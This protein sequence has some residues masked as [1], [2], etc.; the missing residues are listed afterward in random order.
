MIAEKRYYTEIDRLPLKMM[1]NYVLI[2]LNHYNKEERTPGGVIMSSG[3]DDTS[4]DEYDKYD[5]ID[6]TGIV[7]LM[8]D[9]LSFNLKDLTGM[10]WHTQLDIQLGDIVWLDHIDANT[11]ERY[12]YKGDYYKILRY[13]AIIVAKRGIDVICCN[14]YILCS[15]VEVDKSTEY[16]YCPKKDNI[17]NQGVV[18]YVGSKNIEYRS[19]YTYNKQLQFRKKPY[20]IQHDDIDINVGD[21]IIVNTPEVWLESEL[22][23]YFGERVKYL[24]RRFILGVNE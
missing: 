1:P 5:Q 18:R 19:N 14:G 23:Q 24:Q 22:F 13:D 17:I 2:K 4:L 16:I 9:R 6:R 15:S 12:L 21:K 3:L 8:P 10:D 7:V 20:D 11:A